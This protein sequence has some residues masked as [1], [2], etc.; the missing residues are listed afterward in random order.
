MSESEAHVT[1]NVFKDPVLL[2]RLPV[3]SQ[4]CVESACVL[5]A[6]RSYFEREGIFPPSAIDYVAKL[7]RDE[8]DDAMNERLADLPADDRLLETRRIMHRDLHRH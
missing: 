3:L 8:G 2:E 5:L 6:K 1:G 7:L 4:S